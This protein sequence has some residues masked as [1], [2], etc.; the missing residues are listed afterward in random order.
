MKRLDD[1]LDRGICPPV[2]V[3][4]TVVSTTPVEMVE[5]KEMIKVDFSVYGIAVSRII[6]EEFEEEG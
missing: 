6:V 3:L 1:I 2:A 4:E 5:K